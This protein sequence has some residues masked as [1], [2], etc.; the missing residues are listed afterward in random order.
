TGGNININTNSIVAFPNGNNDILANSQQGQGGNITINAESLFGIAEGKAVKGNGTND[1]DASSGIEGLD[2]TVTI[3]TPDI[4][5]IQ[6]ETELP[7]NVV[8]PEQTVAQACQS[9]SA[10]IASQNYLTVKVRGVIPAD[11][12][13]PLDSENVLIN[14]ETI[15][16]SIVPQPI[17]TTQGKIQPARGIKVKPDGGIILTAYQTN[18]SGTRIPESKMNCG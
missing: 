3:N 9:S 14:G 1:I 2:G 11:P 7:S 17:E 10:T 8:E 4:S 12:A 15:P 18:N 13:L 5:S 6:R 16:T